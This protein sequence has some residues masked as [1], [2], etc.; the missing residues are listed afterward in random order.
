[1]ELYP[2]FQWRDGQLITGV[3]DVLNILMPYRAAWRILAW[4]SARNQHL[5]GARPADLLHLVPARV[6]E[7]AQLELHMQ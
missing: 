4:L 2:A 5:E 7:T 1:V 3:R 6:S